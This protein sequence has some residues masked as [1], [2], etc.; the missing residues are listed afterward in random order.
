MQRR[1]W[2]GNTKAMIVLEG[3]KGKSVAELCHEHQISQAQYYQWQDQLLAHAAKAFEVHEQSPR[4]ARLARENTQLKILVG[5]LTRELKKATRCWDA[6]AELPLG[7]S[8]NASL[9]QRIQALKAEHPFWDCRR[10][11]AYLR[12]V[13]QLPVNKKR[14]LWLMREPHLLVKPNPR[15]KTKRTLTRSKPKPTQPNEWWGIDMTT[16]LVQGV[17]W[18]YIVVVLDWYTNAIVGHYAGLHCKAQH[19]LTALDIAVNR[20]FPEGAQGQGLSLMSGNGWQ[21]M[22]TAFRQAC[23]ILGIQ[24]AF[25]SDNNPKATPTP[26]G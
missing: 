22:A 24:Q 11:W 15:L 21:P 20:Q 12:C 19:W 8:V 2:D 25:T 16:V 17:G 7:R 18:I 1:K 9:L 23:S 4:E 13:E 5:E 10:V 3:L 6:S 26:S 14:I